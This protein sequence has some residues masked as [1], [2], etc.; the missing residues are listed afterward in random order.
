MSVIADWCDPL[1]GHQRLDP[2]SLI[3]PHQHCR[4]MKFTLQGLTATLN[5]GSSGFACVEVESH[6]RLLEVVVS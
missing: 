6:P 4:S 5:W 1:T 2:P 3:H